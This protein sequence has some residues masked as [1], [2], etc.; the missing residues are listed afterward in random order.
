MFGRCGPIGRALRRFSAARRGMAAVEFA[1]VALPFFMLTL[2]LAEV[3]MMGFAQTSLDFAMSETA[4]RIRTG[5]AQVA[6]DTYGAV[7]TEL[8]NQ[9][10]TFLILDCSG[11]LYLDVNNYPSFQAAAAGQVNPVQ[12]GQFQANGFGYNP[13]NPADIVVVRAYYR[14]QIMTPLFEPIFQNVGN[15]QRILVSTMMFRNEPYAGGAGG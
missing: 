2:G 7:Q 15:G 8:C 11:N 13:G 4:R 9:F 1:L 14:W 6:G 5:E 12:N 3:S 10:R